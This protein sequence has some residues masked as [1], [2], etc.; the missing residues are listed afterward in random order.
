MRQSAKST[1]C[2]QSSVA[3]TSAVHVA[4]QYQWMTV[5]CTVT[6]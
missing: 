1:H 2:H 5:N 6:H 3:L 4:M